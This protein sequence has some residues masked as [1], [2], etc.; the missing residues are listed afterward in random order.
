MTANYLF[1][2][3]LLIQFQFATSSYPKPEIG[4]NHVC[5]SRRNAFNLKLRGGCDVEHSLPKIR[6]RVWHSVKGKGISKKVIEC[7]DV[8]LDP[9]STCREVKHALSH[10]TNCP[11][12]AMDVILRDSDDEEVCTLGL[13]GEQLGSHWSQP[14]GCSPTPCLH[15]VQEQPVSSVGWLEVRPSSLRTLATTPSSHQTPAPARPAG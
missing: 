13:R 3:F 6:F 5:F 2:F 7:G 8:F 12:S 1:S 9:N 11:V 15:V 10:V 4:T 14:G